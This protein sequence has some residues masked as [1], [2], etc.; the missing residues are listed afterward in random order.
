MPSSRV[1]I[2]ISSGSI[3]NPAGGH[4]CPLFCGTWWVMPVLCLSAW[5]GM[6][7][8]HSYRAHDST[9]IHSY[10]DLAAC[11]QNCQDHH[12]LCCHGCR[13][14]AA[15]DGVPSHTALQRSRTECGNPRRGT[16]VG[17]FGLDARDMCKQMLYAVCYQHSHMLQPS[18]EVH[19]AGTRCCMSC[20]ADLLTNGGCNAEHRYDA[21]QHDAGDADVRQPWRGVVLMI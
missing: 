7:Q 13:R 6:C 14:R 15:A 19:D 2:S 16:T 8:Q 5:S 1:Q 21:C 3:R 18:G 4:K 17:Q 10:T 11:R 20:L 12:R 9:Q